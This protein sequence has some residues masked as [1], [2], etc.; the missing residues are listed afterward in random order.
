MVFA[1][2]AESGGALQNI[3]ELYNR[4][5]SDKV[6]KWIFVTS[7]INLPETENVKSIQIPSLKKSW[8]HRL[9]FDLIDYK[10]LVK[11]YNPDEIHNLQT[12]IYKDNNIKYIFYATNVLFFT[13]IR[14]KPSD[15]FNLFLRQKLLKRPVV[16]SCK[17]SDNII[18]ECEWMALRI[19][20]DLNIDRNKITVM[21][22][23]VQVLWNSD[24]KTVL[25]RQFFYPASGA[26]Y[27]NHKTLVEA[28]KLLKNEG[29]DFKLVL[30]LKG[31]EV[32]KIRVL[33]KE[34]EQAGI[35]VD[36]VG[37]QD[38]NQM[39]EYYLSSILVFP[40]YLETIGLPLLEAREM[41]API[42]CANLP[43][44]TSII[45]DYD[46]AMF[47][48]YDDPVELAELM[49]TALSEIEGNQ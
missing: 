19:A 13:P 17:R 2:A 22:H 31:N 48:Q 16:F 43:Y 12:F 18:T 3:R 10:K 9:K 42:I 39:K 29:Y 25:K 47:F 34:C 32:R 11:Q 28:A 20:N 4:A 8:F 37:T 44:A 40:S 1:T 15:D 45:G 46:K 5:I 30:T 24:Y 7:V 23:N 14:F 38:M 27:K 41:G 35:I 36:W 21:E 6:N 26:V 33:K 49:K